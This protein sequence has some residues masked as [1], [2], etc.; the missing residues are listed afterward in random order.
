[1][2]KV[3]VLLSTYNGETYLR[4]QLDSVLNQQG[5]EVI[6]FVRDDGSK[7]NTVNILKEYQ[8]KGKIIL[9]VGEN[10]GFAKSYLWLN[11]NAPKADYYAFCD[12]D[13]V[14]ESDKLL[15]AT[16]KLEKLDNTKPNLYYSALKVVDKNLKMTYPTSHEGFIP[17]TDEYVFA[18]SL[19]QNWV[20]GCT[21][22]FNESLREYTNSYNQHLYCHDWT[23]YQIA[24]GMGKVI[25][26]ETTHIL[27][28][29]HG[30]NVF[31]FYR[32]GLI[33]WLKNIK[34]FFKTEAKNLRL[35]EA[36]KFARAY[37]DQLPTKNKEYLDT[38]LNYKNNRKDK[39]RLKNDP[40]FKAN[41]IV[42][43][44]HLL[45]INTGKL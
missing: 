44:Y 21:M 16:N 31:G 43:T 15:C 45:L 5:V 41:G 35:N 22:V 24:A 6:F 40:A 30:T 19:M 37:Y 13:D 32:S 11:N 3:C 34:L 1:M 4:E 42:R 33:A 29:Q 39:K 36:Q 18:S 10:L 28:R 27:Y 38:L 23:M 9:N 25:F 14:W 12:Q 20:Y 8:E 17:P 2:I 26:D 7:D